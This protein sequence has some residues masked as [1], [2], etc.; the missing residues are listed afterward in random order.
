MLDPAYTQT[1][2]AKVILRAARDAGWRDADL[3]VFLD[4][5]IRTIGNI[6]AGDTDRVSAATARKLRRLDRRLG[7]AK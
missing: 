4:V 5:S 2:H 3:A 7:R 1:R 6:L